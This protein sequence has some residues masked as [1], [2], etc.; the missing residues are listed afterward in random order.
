MHLCTRACW[1][2][3]LWAHAGR[4]GTGMSWTRARG[5]A[6]PSLHAR[7]KEWRAYVF[8]AH[9][10][11]WRTHLLDACNGDARISWRVHVGA[12]VSSWC[13]HVLDCALAQGDVGV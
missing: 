11:E 13:T 12:R 5:V 6:R 7:K 3:H 10:E 2:C 9:V 4:I 1:R 8:L